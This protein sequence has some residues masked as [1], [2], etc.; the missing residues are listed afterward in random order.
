MG[1]QDSTPP[2]FVAISPD[3][4]S[5]IDLRNPALAAALSWLVP[6]LGQLY[7]RRTTKGG[8]FM[9]G[10]LTAL[11]VGLWLG[12]GRVV[13]ASWRP[14]E[15]RLAFL[16]QAG[17][18]A[19]AV[20]AILQSMRLSGA[21][22]QPYL[23]SSWFAPPLRQGQFVSAAYAERVLAAEP[24][25]ERKAFVDRPPF[26]QCT[27]DQLSVWHER[28][29]RSFD[30]GT[31]YTVLAGMLNLLV[32]YDAWAGPLREAPDAKSRQAKKQA[33]E[34]SGDKATDGAAGSGGQPAATKT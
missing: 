28:L 8:L 9:G 5:T 26:K 34:A 1:R 10:L 13:Y 11:I 2:R 24:S 7:Q 21:A 23:T 16:G 6:G 27:I 15:T 25:L 17:I 22:R 33:G 19:V 29:G 32:V 3:D 4:G 31:L 14:G 20:P 18:G 12:D 30:I